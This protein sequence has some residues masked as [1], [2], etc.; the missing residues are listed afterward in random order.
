MR[1]LALIACALPLLLGASAIVSPPY[2][3]PTLVQ[4]ALKTSNESLN[5][6]TTLQDDDA[7]TLPMVSNGRYAFVAHM[8]VWATNSI[9]PDFRYTFAGSA[10]TGFQ[11]ICTS[12]DVA[13]ATTSTEATI[14]LAVTAQLP[15]SS[16]L[17][18]FQ[19]IGTIQTGATAGN[20]RL[21]W[22]QAVSN[23]ANT[24]VGIGSWLMLR[25]LN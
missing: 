25:K 6:S 22:A 19:C 20:F 23:V 24:N 7:L 21:R 9:T 14:G 18:F 2:A 17:R 5:N 13:G 8:G 12:Q 16:V 4:T 1:R 3:D 10:S 11:A 15:A